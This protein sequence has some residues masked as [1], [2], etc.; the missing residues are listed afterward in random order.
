M[1]WGQPL[2]GTSPASVRGGGRHSPACET[3]PLTRQ[4]PVSFPRHFHP[5]LSSQQLPCPDLLGFRE[6]FCVWLC[7]Q[8]PA[9]SPLPRAELSSCLCSR[10]SPEDPFPVLPSLGLFAELTLQKA[11]VP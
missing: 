8:L 10:G 1:G 4:L 11:G 7:A 5:Q 2:S 6:R 9:L 3:L